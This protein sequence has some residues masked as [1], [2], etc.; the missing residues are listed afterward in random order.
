MKQSFYLLVSIATLE[1]AIAATAIVIVS[2]DVGCQH[3][4]IQRI[5][6]FVFAFFS[7]NFK[8]ENLFILNKIV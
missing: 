4:Y 8:N 3:S 1:A 5:L 2:F 6:E 7:S